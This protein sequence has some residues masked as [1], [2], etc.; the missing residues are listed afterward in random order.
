MLRKEQ[1]S[2]N[3]SVTKEA[4]MEPKVL[5][6]SSME[7]LFGGI[8]LPVKKLSKQTNILQN[9]TS[10]SL[11]V[12]KKGRAHYKAL[13]SSLFVCLELSFSPLS[14]PSLFRYSNSQ[15]NFS[16]QRRRGWVSACARSCLKVRERKTW[17]SP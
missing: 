7:C 13:N 4:R 17:C 6:E 10:R 8:F 11:I 2:W 9:H 16:F 1:H 3:I 5:L 15:K 12:Y 14:S